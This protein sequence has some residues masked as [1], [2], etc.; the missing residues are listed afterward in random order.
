MPLLQQH[1]QLLEELPDAVGLVAG[2]GD[3]VAADDDQHVVE[4]A[5]DEP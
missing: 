2:D 1:D 5:L 3:L 4:R